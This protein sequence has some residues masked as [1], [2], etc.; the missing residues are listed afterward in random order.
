MVSG[1]SELFQ[2]YTGYSIS[3]LWVESPVEFNKK[4]FPPIVL[5]IKELDCVAQEHSR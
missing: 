4:T 1:A 3:E 5:N 2:M